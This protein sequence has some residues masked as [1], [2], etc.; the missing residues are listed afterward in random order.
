[1]LLPSAFTRPLSTL[2]SLLGSSEGMIT[3]TPLLSGCRAPSRFFL[4]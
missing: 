2:A 4:R 3:F 1:M